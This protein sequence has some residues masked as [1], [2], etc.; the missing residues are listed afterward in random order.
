M[1]L[2][3]DRKNTNQRMSK[4]VLYEGL[5]FLSG[6]TASGSSAETIE[7]QTAEALRRVEAH[8]I[9]SGSGKHRLLS[10]TVYLRRIDDFAA[11]NILW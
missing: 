10:T 3:I 4:A 1:A 8:L 11:M 2:V 9:E 6:Q 7:E 5:V